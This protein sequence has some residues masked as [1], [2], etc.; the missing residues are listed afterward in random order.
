MYLSRD[1]EKETNICKRLDI[2]IMDKVIQSIKD[3]NRE[4]RVKH[5]GDMTAH[6]Y[7]DGVSEETTLEEETPT[8]EPSLQVDTKDNYSRIKDLWLSLPTTERAMFLKS[9]GVSRAAAHKLVKKFL[10][11]ERMK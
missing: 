6:G 2:D 9:V 3:F 5:E 4:I 10:E 1:R 7:R 11:L 8:Q